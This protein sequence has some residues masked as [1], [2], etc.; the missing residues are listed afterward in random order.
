MI[1]YLCDGS[2]FLVV[3]DVPEF[4]LPGRHV[5]VQKDGRDFY[6]PFREYDVCAIF[7]T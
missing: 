5:G 1:K 6:A 2:H 3:A 7:V 4:E